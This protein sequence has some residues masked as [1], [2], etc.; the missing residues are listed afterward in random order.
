MSLRRRVAGVVAEAG[1][2]GQPDPGGPEYRDDRGVAALGEAAARAGLFQPGQLFSGE[3]G[4]QLAGDARRLQA[5]HRV[6]QQVFGGQPFEELLQGAVLVAGVGVAVAVQQPGHPLLDVLA[7][8]LLPAGP[9][10]LPGQASGE[11]LHRLGVGPYCLGG[12]ALGGQ[13]Q[14][15]RADLSLECPGVQV[16]GL[17]GTRFLYGHGLG[18]LPRAHHPQPSVSAGG[19]FQSITTTGK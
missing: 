7:A 12:L 14:G 16:L 1:Q 10:A 19:R 15:E 17:P 18:S 11:P 2:L 5:F 6:G 13:A 3:D 8:H 4:D 9:A